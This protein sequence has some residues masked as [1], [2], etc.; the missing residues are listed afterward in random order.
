MSDRRWRERAR[1]GSGDPQ[2]E[3]ELLALQLRQGTLSPANLSL[4]A[5]LEHAPALHVLGPRAPHRPSSLESWLRGLAPWGP[6]T[7]GWAALGAAEA[8][9]PLWEARHDDLR[10]REALVALEAWLSE[11]NPERAEAALAAG[12]AC[13]AILGVLPGPSRPARTSPEEERA[14]AFRETR[15]CA[16]A[17]ATAGPESVTLR[18]A[19]LAAVAARER[20]A[21]EEVSPGPGGQ[22]LF[23][24]AAE[25]DRLGHLPELNTQA[26]EARLRVGIR[27][28]LLPYAL[29]GDLG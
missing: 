7:W 26:S 16:L 22:S 19:V 2:D 25:V 4:A 24:R 5:Y 6:L 15:A 1:A 12:E 23:R 14:L 10:P 8:V 18:Q 11:P 27:A 13:Y 20:L 28:R 21:L 3:A 17:A 9:L 29:A